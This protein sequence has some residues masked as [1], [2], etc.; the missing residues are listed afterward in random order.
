MTTNPD[1]GF[2]DLQIE[3]PQ[4]DPLGEYDRIV[5]GRLDLDADHGIEP[6]QI[7]RRKSDHQR[8]RITRVSTICIGWEL[9]DPPLGF[10]VSEPSQQLWAE[11]YELEDTP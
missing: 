4:Y 2:V 10:G 9:V 5:D 6:G 1:D 3:F 11:N 8:V 7:W